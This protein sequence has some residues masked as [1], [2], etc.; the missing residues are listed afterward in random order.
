MAPL[1]RENRLPTG[2]KHIPTAEQS[3]LVATD[4]QNHPLAIDSNRTFDTFR[5]NG[6]QSGFFQLA[7]GEAEQHP[8]QRQ[9]SI[10]SSLTLPSPAPAELV[11]LLG[12]KHGKLKAGATVRPHGQE[13]ISYMGADNSITS[14]KPVNMTTLER[15]KPRPRVQLNLRLAGDTFVQGQTISGQLVVYVRSAKFPV[16]LA[17]NKLRVIGFEC[18]TDGPNF[19]VFFYRS[20]QFEEISYAG[21]QIFSES[22]DYSDEEGYREAREG[23]HVLPFEM[24]LPDDSSCGKPKG[25]IDIRGAA[26]RYIVMVY[27]HSCTIGIKADS[28]FQFRQYKRSRHKSTVAGPL[29]PRVFDLALD[30]YP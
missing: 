4:M 22:P 20:Y 28:V 30:A 23:T 14:Q 13:G 2:P 11:C 26:L 12:D 1:R 16:Y 5:A 25:V 10:I 18:L 6:E 9:P 24:T 27:A 7:Q 17:N 19:H 21:E 29:L 15:A 8:V 3:S